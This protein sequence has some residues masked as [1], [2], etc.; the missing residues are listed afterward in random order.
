VES[1]AR[2]D[3]GKERWCHGAAPE[4]CGAEVRVRVGRGGGVL[5]CAL[6]RGGGG[7]GGGAPSGHLPPPP[8]PPRRPRFWHA[9]L[10]PPPSRSES[11]G[12]LHQLCVT[13]PSR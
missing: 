1:G 7:G 3:I 9:V 11:L 8:P 4:P 2:S 12:P 13:A 6:A 10:P 5:T